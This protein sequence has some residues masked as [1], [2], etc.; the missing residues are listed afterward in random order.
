M[1]NECVILS[2]FSCGTREVERNGI[3]QKSRGGRRKTFFR[4]IGAYLGQ[5]YLEVMQSHTGPL[6]CYTEDLGQSQYR[7]SSKRINNLPRSAPDPRPSHNEWDLGVEFVRQRF[8]LD[9]S[10]LSE[11]VAVIGC[12]DNVAVGKHF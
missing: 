4:T 12:E 8:A 11:V 10:E 3:E 2:P 6:R 1:I 9:N 7:K 5:E